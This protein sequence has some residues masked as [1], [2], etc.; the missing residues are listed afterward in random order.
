[1]LA[2]HLGSNVNIV[3]SMH[4]AKSRDIEIVQQKKSSTKGFTNLISLSLKTSRGEWNIAGT[5]MNGY[6]ARIVQIQNYTVDLPPEGN[7]ILVSHQD[8]PGIIGKLG[9]ILGNNDVN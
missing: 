9:T 6:G 7:L 2:S 1:V 3:N 4:V 5:L 8:K